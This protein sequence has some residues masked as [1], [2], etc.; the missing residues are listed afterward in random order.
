MHNGGCGRIIWRD[1]LCLFCKS[2]EGFSPACSRSMHGRVSNNDALRHKKRCA[3]PVEIHYNT[4]RHEHTPR[5]GGLARVAGQSCLAGPSVLRLH[6]YSGHTP[7]W[8]IVRES[9]VES[10]AVFCALCLARSV[11]A[12]IPTSPIPSLTTYYTLHPVGPIWGLGRIIPICLRAQACDIP[13]PQTA[14]QTQKC[15][16]CRSHPLRS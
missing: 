15:P 4:S 11:S 9:R 8:G 1:H 5:G 2:C 12:F 10:Q 7:G 16:L 14:C 13:R 6:R 3:H